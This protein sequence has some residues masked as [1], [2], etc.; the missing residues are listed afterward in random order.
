MTERVFFDTNVLVYFFSEA[1]LHTEIAESLLVEGGVVSVQVLNELV[2]VARGK[3]GMSWNE[4]R[5]A[6]DKTLVFCPSPVSLTE[7]LHRTAVELSAR[8]GYRIYDSLVL[9]AAMQA[10]CTTVYSEDMQHGQLI[11]GVRIENPFLAP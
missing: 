8:Y 9:A 7:E 2:S 6:R 5:S 10:G 1:G 11:D 4:V 3:L